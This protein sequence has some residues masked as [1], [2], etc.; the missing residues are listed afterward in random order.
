MTRPL[1]TL[2]LLLLTFN[3]FTAIANDEKQLEPLVDV[4]WLKQHLNDSNLVILDTS[5]IISFNEQGQFSFRSG[6]DAYD[7]SHIPHA[8]F[9]DLLG[10]LSA[11]DTDLRFIMPSPQQ[12]QKAISDLG[13]SND[14]RVVIYS[15]KPDQSWAQRLWWMLKW[16]GHDKIAILDGGFNAWLEAGFPVSNKPVNPVKAQFKLNLKNEIIADRNEVYKAIND[17][18]ITIID[19][20]PEAH[21]TGAFSMYARPGHIKSA[22]NIPTGKLVTDSGHYK[23]IDE[24][25]ILFKSKQENR[26][27]T[28]CGSGVA[29]SSTAF[30]LHKLGYKDV[31]VYMG[32][33]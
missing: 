20:L 24:L 14:S 5:V 9:A 25:K 2:I 15:T 11:T 22:I 3:T 27:I 13:V 6:K 12:F 21:Y 32:S 19:T 23:N 29:A 16:A 33:L 10:E 17:K 26:I 1:K 31:A 30:T 18:N 28:Y 8:I 7:D 4:H